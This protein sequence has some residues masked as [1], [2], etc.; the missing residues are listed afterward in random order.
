LEDIRVDEDEKCSHA[1][2]PDNGANNA[3]VANHGKVLE[4]EGLS[5]AVPG[6]EDDGWEDDRKK[7]FIIELNFGM[8]T[9]HFNRYRTYLAK[10]AVRTPMKMAI[11]DS[12][13]YGT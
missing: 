2:K 7:N 8:Q 1:D 10:I 4:E 6:R 11:V 5:E 3:Q 13:R 9:L 12:C